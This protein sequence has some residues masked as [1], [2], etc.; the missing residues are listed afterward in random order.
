MSTIHSVHVPI[1]CSD[2]THK[3]GAL[4]SLRTIRVG[5]PTLP[6]TVHW[7]TPSE[8]KF[9]EI[10]ISIN[11][12]YD[13]VIQWGAPTTNDQIIKSLCTTEQ[14]GF[15]VVDSD[16]VFFDNCE[17]FETTAQ[18]AGEFIPAFDC[19][20]AK[21]RTVCRLHTAF[22]VLSDPPTLRKIIS[23]LYK[24][25]FPQFCPFDPFAPVTTFSHRRPIFYDSCAI[26]YQAIGGDS[27]DGAMLDKFQHL[28]GGSYAHLLPFPHQKF[29][30]ECFETPS[31]AKGFRNTMNRFFSERKVSA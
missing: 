17:G 22:L 28:Y 13:K 16:C 18:I 30:D 6:I 1:Y 4:L 27:F 8:L 15:A 5:F 26:L 9:E 21:A 2:A 14:K 19:P 12:C 24:P 7:V 20:I 3:A 11:C 23:E 25:A 10:G 29:I 31:K